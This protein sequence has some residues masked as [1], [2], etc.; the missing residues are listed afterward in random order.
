MG[1]LGGAYETAL[2][3]LYSDWH[4]LLRDVG[5]GPNERVGVG[6]LQR[7]RAAVAL[8]GHAARRDRRYA[9]RHRG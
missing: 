6:E 1:Q 7:D 8:T 5:G 4:D 3:E 2:R 9:G